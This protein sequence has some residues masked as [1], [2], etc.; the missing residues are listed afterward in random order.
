MGVA[1][2]ILG[3]LEVLRDGA[4]VEPSGAKLRALLID[5][6]VHRTR[7]RTG[8][9]LV[10]DLWAGRPPATAPGVLRTYLSPLRALLGPGGRGRRAPRGRG[11]PPGAGGRH[12]GPRAPR[13]VRGGGAAARPRRGARRGRRP[14]G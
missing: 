13:R 7:F 3:P 11:A 12:P 1:F 5:L 8:E 2:R 4:R 10:D 9:Q 14:D 6:L